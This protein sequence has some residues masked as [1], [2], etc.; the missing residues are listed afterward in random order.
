MGQTGR[1]SIWCYI[2]RM[3][4][5]H[6]RS[7]SIRYLGETYRRY[8]DSE[9]RSLR[10]YFVSQRGRRLHRAV[11]EHHVGPIPDGHH[12]HHLDENP[13]NNDIGNLQCLP[14]TEH[15]RMHYDDERREWALSLIHI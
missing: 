15:V 10:V 13:L 9:D 12:I 4:N 6:G 14:G 11:W 5:K 2:G 8:P 7:E 1:A 3:P